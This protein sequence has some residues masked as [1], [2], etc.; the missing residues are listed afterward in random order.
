MTQEA[1][2]KRIKTTTDLRGIVSTMK[3]L[4]SVSVGQFERAL[5]SLNQYTENLQN[6]FRGLFAQENFH[7]NPP[8]N[9]IKKQKILAILIGSDNGLVGPFN[10]E[11]LDNMKKILE[12][13]CDKNQIK[14]ISVG[15]RLSAM[16]TSNGLN[17][18]A[19]YN[20]SNTTKEVSALAGALLTKIHQLLTKDQ[21]DAVWLFYT[22]RQDMKTSVIGEQM[23][24]FQQK[25]LD[26]IKTK[27]WD[28]K[29]LPLITAEYDELFS[30]LIREHFI[31]SLSHA[32]TASLATEHYTRMIHMQQAEKN[33]DEKLAELELIYQQERQNQITNEL[34]DIVSGAEAINKTQ[35][36][37]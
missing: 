33:I 21:F 5:K 13:I 17:L 30:A 34:I 8:I 22:V 2:N 25:L 6:A 27:K 37:A 32:L 15:K 29:T 19:H 24:P 20:N 9:R 18:L 12:P 7:Y 14:I 35:K 26:H 11:I 10:R 31:V 23:I 1:L 3:M 4:S 28:G 16:I 36:N